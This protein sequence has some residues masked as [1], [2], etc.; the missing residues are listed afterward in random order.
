M[1]D[2]PPPGKDP[3]KLKSIGTS[4]D[5][6]ED[7]EAP[8]DADSCTATG[9]CSLPTS[10][11]TSAKSLGDFEFSSS[12]FSFDS[13]PEADAIH[14]S[15]SKDNPLSELG[16]NSRTDQNGCTG[17]TSYD[18]SLDMR[19]HLRS[20]K[21]TTGEQKVA[22]NEMLGQR[23]PMNILPE[24]HMRV[25]NT[26]VPVGIAE[27]QFSFQSKPS[28]KESLSPIHVQLPTQ[29]SLVRPDA[30][31]RIHP[32]R[33]TSFDEKPYFSLEDNTNISVTCP[34]ATAMTA[35]I[36]TLPTQSTANNEVIKAAP[37]ISSSSS[38]ISVR[39]EIPDN[40]LVRKLPRRIIHLV[41]SHLQVRQSQ[42]TWKEL[43]ELHDWN[44]DRTYLFEHQNHEEGIFYSLLREPEF[45]DYNLEKLRQDLYYLPRKDILHDL[46]EMISAHNE[47]A[48]SAQSRNSTR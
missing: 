26:E 37:P 1:A 27:R 7:T 40:C 14:L 45:Q 11:E 28:F 42:G 4:G 36:D 44:Y 39:S 48:L 5:N 2:T 18:I 24:D 29:E 9:G 38:F 25:N 20:N 30:V 23:M 15:H 3:E 41:A 32:C 43:V 10:D 16:I 46:N 8:G 34:G 21:V 6:E 31:Y 35:K 17:A 47:N 22:T 12:K 33:N 19:H 13:H